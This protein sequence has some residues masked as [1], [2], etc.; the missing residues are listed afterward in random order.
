MEADNN[1][2]K[3]QSI[4]GVIVQII[5]GTLVRVDTPWEVWANII[6]E[7]TVGQTIAK[8]YATRLVVKRFWDL[9][10]ETANRSV[11]AKEDWTKDKEYR[12]KLQANAEACAKALTLFV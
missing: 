10:C 8:G 4:D 1:T 2:S 5:D 9:F 3:A 11:K 7:K 12:T 6:K